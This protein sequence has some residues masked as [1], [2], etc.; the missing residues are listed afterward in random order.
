MTPIIRPVTRSD[1]PQLHHMI[2][3]LA[4]HHGDVPDISPTHLARDAIGAGA[5]F[6]VLVA[7]GKNGCL[8]G[9]AALNPV[10]QLQL[11]ARGLD[12][13]HLFVRE[14]S[15]GMGV[16]T[17]LLAA[18]RAFATERECAF[19]TVGS[20]P[21]NHEAA[22]FYE[23]RGFTRRLGSGHRFSMKLCAAA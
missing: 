23:T 19:L 5:W 16:G 15:R 2:C 9:Y 17:A 11:G 4:A 13:H 21:D 7:E 18:C 14:G 1:L 3:A 10:G 12:L 20:H 6:H 22:A 8:Q